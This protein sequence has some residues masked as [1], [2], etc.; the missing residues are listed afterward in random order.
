MVWIFLTA[1]DQVRFLVDEA[2]QRASSVG[3]SFF[4]IDQQYIYSPAR[5]WLFEDADFIG[6]EG[7]LG[8]RLLDHV[9]RI[10]KCG[11]RR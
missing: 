4:Q 7:R 8:V 2:I 6:F 1:L 11:S 3:G 10:L 5:K 9:M